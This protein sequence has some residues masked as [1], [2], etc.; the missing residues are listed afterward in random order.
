M[1]QG[2]LH[3]VEVEYLDDCRYPEAEQLLWE[4]EATAT[5]LGTTSLPGVDANRPDSPTALRPSSTP[6]A[7]PG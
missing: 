1:R 2:R 6:T 5:V 3:I 7:G 4:V